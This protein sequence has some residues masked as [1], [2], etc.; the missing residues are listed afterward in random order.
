V[1]QCEDAQEVS[2]SNAIRMTAKIN[3]YFF[4][5]IVQ[6]ECAGSK[7][8]NKGIVSRMA[9]WLIVLSNPI[10]VIIAQK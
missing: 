5:S 9:V 3:R 1:A 8:M 10:Y 2:A 7:G 4:I 6:S